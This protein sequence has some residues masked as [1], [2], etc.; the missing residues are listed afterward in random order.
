MIKIFERREDQIILGGIKKAG[1]TNMEVMELKTQLAGPIAQL[2]FII[3]F[4]TILFWVLK[5]LFSRERTTLHDTLFN[6]RVIKGK[7]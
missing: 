3:V 6:T 7:K 2:T 1:K 4:F 5:M